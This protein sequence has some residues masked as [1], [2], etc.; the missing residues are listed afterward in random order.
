MRKILT[1]LFLLIGFISNAQYPTPHQ[2]VGRK[3]VAVDYLGGV[4]PLN[5][6]APPNYLDTTSANDSVNTNLYNGSFIF[7]TSDKNLWYRSVVLNKWILVANGGSI[8]N[9]IYT[10]DDTLA[11]NRIVHGNNKTLQFNGQSIFTIG[12]DAAI[13]GFPYFYFVDGSGESDWESLDQAGTTNLGRMQL[14][15]NTDTTSLLMQGST[16]EYLNFGNLH[17]FMGYGFRDS[18]GVMQ[19]KNSTGSWLSFS[20]GVPSINIFNSNGTLTGNRTLTGGGNDL[21]FTGLNSFGLSATNDITE[22]SLDGNIFRK[23]ISGNINDTANNITIAAATT[24][25][26]TTTTQDCGIS[27]SGIDGSVLVATT[28]GGLLDLSSSGDIN[29]GMSGTLLINSVAGT[30]GQV[31]TAH[32]AGVPITWETPS[33]GGG[34]VGLQQAITNNP[35]LNQDN[36]IGVFSKNLILDSIGSFQLFGQGYQIALTDSLGQWFHYS[37]DGTTN[38]QISGQLADGTFDIFGIHSSTV[39]NT[40]HLAN[41]GT[42]TLK[43]FTDGQG[44][45]WLGNGVGGTSGEVDFNSNADINLQSASSADITLLSGQ[46]TNITAGEGITLTSG[47]AENI[48]LNPAASLVT[49]AGNV[50]FNHS[51]DFVTNNTTYGH[52]IEALGAG[53]VNISSFHGNNITLSSDADFNINSGISGSGGVNINS[54][55]A[56]INLTATTFGSTI[57][58]QDNGVIILNSANSKK[59]EANS[60]A[61]INLIAVTSTRITGGLWLNYRAISSDD[62]ILLSDYYLDVS[63]TTTVT[64]PNTGIGAGE[65][66]VITNVDVGVVTV[67]GNGTNIN[68]SPTQTLA[69]TNSMSIHFDGT[70]W[71]IN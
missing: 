9:T 51:S 42:L 8:G 64:L 60:A 69:A 70:N 47:D 37:T 11:S 71:V 19:Y 45:Q 18:M 30:E 16:V 35:F 62:N 50:I 15:A 4:F 33:G 39:D 32:G 1:I 12:T 7:T 65:T 3:T 49:N 52:Q 48:T 14:Q 10:G 38:N 54:T 55:G 41:D 61:E 13:S 36:T 46:E 23:A 43:S 29:L 17:A 34:S 21:S 24:A 5:T 66:F 57:I 2:Q 44:F 59:I 25:T 67:D 53:G 40:F 20:A 63:G 58:N 26:L 6:F 56:D 68:G 28:S 31:P 27:A 22:T